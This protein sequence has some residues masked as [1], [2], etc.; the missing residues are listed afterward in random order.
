MTE[1]NES[2][3]SESESE[4]EQD[5]DADMFTTKSGMKWLPMPLCK[6]GQRPACNIF[7]NQQHPEKSSEWKDV[8]AQ[9]I[10][11]SIALLIAAGKI[12]C[13]QT[14]IP[15]LW[16]SHPAFRNPFFT[17]TMSRSRFQLL[18]TF[19]RLDNKITRCTRIEE[20]GD[21]L[22][23]I[24]EVFDIFVKGC[25][26]N[27]SPMENLTVDVRLAAFSG[28]CPFR[29]YMKSKSGRYGIKIWI[30]SDS[31]NGYV[32]NLQ[33]YTGVRNNQSEIN[34]DITIVSYVPKKRK[35]IVL[36]STR[37]HDATIHEDEDR[38]PE[39]IQHYN[40][41]KGGVDL[42]DMSSEYSCVRMTIRWPL[43]LFMEIIDIA[44]LNTYILWRKKTTRNG[45]KITLGR[46]DAS[47]MNWC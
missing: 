28:K 43:R 11:A 5:R 29:V 33:L 22:Q 12:H 14:A 16:T 40:V 23:A 32:L 3:G 47:F 4:E 24:R 7:F 9:E 27:H 19:L 10:P 18:C 26:Q 44:A 31:A 17:A 41:T 42:G 6:K 8:D 20:S 25:I 34:Q 39:I 37:Y 13:N 46:E 45:A 36:L 2:N 1:A 30:C 35:A 21:K 15:E 38:K